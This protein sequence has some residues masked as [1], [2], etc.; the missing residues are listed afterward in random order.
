[1]SLVGF[2]EEL[3]QAYK[4]EKNLRVLS[5]KFD[6][7][8]QRLSTKL[9]SMGIYEKQKYMTRKEIFEEMSELLDTDINC[10]KRFLNNTV[11]RKIL[12]GIK[13]YVS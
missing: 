9:V 6:L 13:E 8:K 3:R 7:T 10:E 12:E 5:K 1:M 11:L 4:T 2:E